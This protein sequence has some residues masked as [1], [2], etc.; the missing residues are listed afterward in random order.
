MAIILD[1]SH[2]YIVKAVQHQLAHPT[3]TLSTVL[4][5]ILGYLNGSKYKGTIEINGVNWRLQHFNG[6]FHNMM[7]WI[8]CKCYISIPLLYLKKKLYLCGF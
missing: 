7:Y 4:P 6:D 3:I 1:E 2:G 5:Q 8:S